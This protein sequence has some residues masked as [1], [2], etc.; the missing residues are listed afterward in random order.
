MIDANDVEAAA[1]VLATRL[2]EDASESQRS[3]EPSAYQSESQQSEEGQQLGIEEQDDD[4]PPSPSAMDLLEQHRK[5]ERVRRA[6]EMGSTFTMLEY[7]S[8]KQNC[9]V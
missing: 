5:A 2:S 6:S 3:H 4:R 8:F 7:V 9:L 1:K